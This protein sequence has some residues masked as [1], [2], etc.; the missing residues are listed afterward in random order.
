MP[1]QKNNS[2]KID[3]PTPKKSKTHTHTYIYIYKYM[4]YNYKY[5]NKKI[6]VFTCVYLPASSQTHFIT[7]FFTFFN[8]PFPGPC[9]SGK[10]LT[11]SQCEGGAVPIVYT[12]TKGFVV[13]AHFRVL[14]TPDRNF[15]QKKPPGSKVF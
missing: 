13:I 8:P 3:S 5:I 4:L 2:S 11:L 7:C 1:K 10:N 9:F 12:R 6:H 15:N 14:V